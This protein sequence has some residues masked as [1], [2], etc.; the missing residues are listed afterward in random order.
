[1]PTIKSDLTNKNLPQN[2]LREIDIPDETG[3]HP[4]QEFQ[5]NDEVDFDAMNA[6]MAS[7]NLPPVDPSIVSAYNARQ[8]AKRGQQLNKEDIA[9]LERQVADAKRAKITGKERLS[10]AAKQR[11]ELLLGASRA[12]VTVD[13]DGNQFVLK[14]LKGKEQR[15]AV[16]A[17]SE[18]DHTVESPFEIRKQLLARAIFEVG[19]T[20]VE[21]FLNDSSIEARLEFIEELDEPILIKLYDEYLTLVRKTQKKY[22]ITSEADAKEVAEDLK[23]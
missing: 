1:M 10:Y 13:I 23:K 4:S 19:G 8:A 12:T 18:F 21:L 7:R 3:Y 6:L 17:A 16:K 20:D 9:D 22:M 5:G 2:R 14:T 15:D 11:I